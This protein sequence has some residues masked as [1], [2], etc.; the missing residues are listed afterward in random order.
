[1]TTT[2]A[3][4]T[5]VLA[6]LLFIM[7]LKGLSQ[8]ESARRGNLLGTVGMIL[9]ILVTGALLFSPGAMGHEP[10]AP[11]TYGLLAAMTIGQRAK[12]LARA[13]VPMEKLGTDEWV[14]V[15]DLFTGGR[16]AREAIPAVARRMAV[17]GMSAE[18]AA[19]AEGL[20]LEPREAWA[21][22]VGAVS[23]DG[24]FDGKADSRDRR[25]RFLTGRAVE[26]LNGRAPAKD[27]AAYVQDH[28]EEIVR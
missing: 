26:L 21:P 9:A 8:P 18:A 24:Y 27:V 13:G 19:A 25:V 23:W 10:A 1:M 22:R 15:F 4:A 11:A 20:G 7:S 12:A 17:D 3:N 6:S 16:I 5:Y 14:Q 2:F 28:L